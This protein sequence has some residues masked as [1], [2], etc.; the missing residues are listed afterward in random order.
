MGHRKFSLPEGGRPSKKRK[1]AA[2][3]GNARNRRDHRGVQAGDSKDTA[4]PL[5]NVNNG[6]HE[7]SQHTIKHV[8]KKTFLKNVQTFYVMGSFSSVSS[9][10]INIF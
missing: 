4:T 6:L 3:R 1:L 10:K 7:F 8:A 9:R 5:S 2:K